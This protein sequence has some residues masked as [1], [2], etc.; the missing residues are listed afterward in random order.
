MIED[1]DNEFIHSIVSSNFL[2]IKFVMYI[3][4]LDGVL[5]CTEINFRYFFIILH[6]YYRS[7]SSNSTNQIGIFVYLDYVDET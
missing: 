7:I 6:D 3:N 2:K 4:W 5:I 1:I